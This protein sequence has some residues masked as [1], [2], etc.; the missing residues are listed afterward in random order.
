ME[1][2]MAQKTITE[3][4]ET[5]SRVW[6]GDPAEAIANAVLDHLREER[7]ELITFADV[8]RLAGREDIDEDITRSLV[9]LAA[10]PAA[11][12]TSVMRFKDE[13]G[14][15]IEVAKR[16]LSDDS[17]FYHPV[18]G[19]EVPDFA[20]RVTVDFTVNDGIYDSAPRP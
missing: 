8:V 3:A 16:D 18:T 2:D 14:T 9:I 13:D 10:S 17:P 7:P 5:I 15:I 20:D 4:R 12:L 11:V 6:G 1:R 19:A